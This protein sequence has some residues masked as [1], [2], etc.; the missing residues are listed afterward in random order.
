MIHSYTVAFMYCAT[1][2]RIMIINAKTEVIIGVYCRIQA[3][4]VIMTRHNTGGYREY[5][6]RI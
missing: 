5:V 6:D 3:R 2:N 4:C 1:M